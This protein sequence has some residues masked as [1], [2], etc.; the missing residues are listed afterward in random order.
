MAEGRALEGLGDLV[1]GGVPR[2]R[3]EP[4]AALGADPLQRLLQP[5]GTM[6]P[7][8]VAG[9]LGAHH[10]VGLAVRGGP[11]D[12]PDPRRGQPLDLER[13]GARAI[14]RAGRLPELFSH[15]RSEPPLA[16]VSKRCRP[17]S[18]VPRRLRVSTCMTVAHFALNPGRNA[19]NATRARDG[20]RVLFQEPC[21]PTAPCAK[22][23]GRRQFDDYREVKSGHPKGGNR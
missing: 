21:G 20:T 5:V 2:D 12:A 9:D 10:A 8:G 18:R 14:V 16:R 19:G 22:G 7:L 3:T 15:A 13:A 17:S 6:D 1:E 11:S 4:P 23:S